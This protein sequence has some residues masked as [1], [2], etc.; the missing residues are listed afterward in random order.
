MKSTFKYKWT[1]QIALAP[2]VHWRF[3]DNATFAP[4]STRL[5]TGGWTATAKARVAAFFLAIPRLQ[6]SDHLPQL[7]PEMWLM[8]LQAAFAR[9]GELG[10]T[11]ELEL[12]MTRNPIV[13]EEYGRLRL[14]FTP[15]GLLQGELL[16]PAWQSLVYHQ[17]DGKRQPGPQ[18]Y[19]FTG[20]PVECGFDPDKVE[21]ER[22]ENFFLRDLD[23]LSA[24]ETARATAEEQV[25]NKRRAK[26]GYPPEELDIR[27]FMDSGDESWETIEVRGA[28][29]SGRP[30]GRCHCCG[31]SAQGVGPRR[32]FDYK[33]Q[34]CGGCVDLD[35]MSEADVALLEDRHSLPVW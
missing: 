10:G 9:P 28:D 7:P 11:D 33:Q 35:E 14:R 22:P 19:F 5:S 13:A 17:G 34:I 12:K 31:R 6:Q 24:A 4:S 18:S 20:Y 26:V 25:R 3:G 1:G 8:V 32:G 15:D 29:W 27:E 16:R 30:G 2:L 23:E 21:S